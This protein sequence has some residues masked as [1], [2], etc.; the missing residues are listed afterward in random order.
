MVKYELR[1]KGFFVEE[2]FPKTRAVNILWIILTLVFIA[3]T[4]AS[5]FFFSNPG[6]GFNFDVQ[7]SSRSGFDMYGGDDT[8]IYL[9]ENIGKLLT[10]GI[11]DTEAAGYLI[12]GVF[13]L[14]AYLL[15]KLFVTIL[16]CHKSESIKM[17]I[18]E[19]RGMPICLCKEALKV[20]QTVMIYL[21]PFI[22]MYASY[23]FLCL[24]YI[25][26]P[27]FIV[28][29][30]FMLF[31]MVFDF[32]LIVY[33]LAVKIKRKPD[34]ISIDHHIYGYTLFNKTYIK[35]GRKRRKIK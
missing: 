8:F 11:L 28:L 2:R 16:F 29:F 12:F 25:S 15:L 24:K 21:L 26:H 4:F 33:I 34:Y 7:S 27:V 35:S 9:I 3:G 10:F 22:F 23:Y 13:S 18:L 30:F 1:D 6:G 5:L 20:W 14:F 19:N 17:K 31:F 32:T